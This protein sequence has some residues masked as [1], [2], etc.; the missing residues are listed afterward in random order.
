M[1]CDIHCY[2]E[3]QVD[4]KWLTA[5][6][7]EDYDYGEDDKGKEVPWKERFTGRNYQLFGM[8][9]R[10]VR[11]EHPFSFEPRGLPFNPCAEIASEAER[12]EGDGHN[13][14]YLYLH[15]LKDMLAY[16]Q[17]ATIRVTSMKGKAG[18]Q[19]LR[20]SIASGNPDW[21]L[22]FPYCGWTS[23]PESEEFELDVPASFYM[24]KE[25][26]QIID[27]FDGVDGD[28]HRIVFFFDN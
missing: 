15:E 22:L 18:L 26:K 4:G 10:G 9:A 17:T 16:L 19:E 7:W 11:C 2:K 24:G 3:K 21:K 6:I 25:L 13:H 28:N 8:L 20:D 1:G 12:W 14:S 23:D 27:S 5:D